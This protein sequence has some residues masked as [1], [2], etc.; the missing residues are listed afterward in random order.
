MFRKER[1]GSSPVRGTTMRYFI[2]T[3]FLYI[4]AAY[5]GER[6]AAYWDIV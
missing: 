5:Y 4:V 6:K 1:T 2:V 3:T